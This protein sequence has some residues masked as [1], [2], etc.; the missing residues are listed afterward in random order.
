MRE[1]RTSGSARGVLGNRHS[2]RE[3]PSM[4]MNK[5][6]FENQFRKLIDKRI[7]QVRYYEI[8]YQ[9][10][11]NMWSYDKRFDSLDYGLD[12]L[13]D[14]DSLFA[15]SWGSEFYQYGISPDKNNLPKSNG[16]RFIDVTKTSRWSDFLNINIADVRI[17]WSWIQEFGLFKKK[18]YY[19]QDLILSF[20]SQRK[21]FIS[22]LQ[23]ENDDSFMGMTDNITVFFDGGTA[24][25]FKV[26]IEA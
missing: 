5:S 24:K 26:E 10:N 17:A 9:D 25:K 4:N 3:M 22:A 8:E 19:P 1:N 23:I 14:D 18:I 11:E 7:V 15:I 12:L 21:I 16:C 2:Y 13:T 6:D 20:E